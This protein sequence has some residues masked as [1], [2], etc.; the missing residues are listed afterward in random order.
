MIKVSRH[1]QITHLV[2]LDF[3][4]L[5]AVLSMVSSAGAVVKHTIPRPDPFVDPK[6][7]PY[8]P[9]RYTATNSLT[10]VAF[11]QSFFVQDHLPA[12]RGIQHSFC[13]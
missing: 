8:N 3:L 7:D 10:G 9:F 5:P 1:F 4:G 6:H 2:G 12:H 13:S 11:C